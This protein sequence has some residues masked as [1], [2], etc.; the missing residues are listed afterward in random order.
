[1][2]IQKSFELTENEHN[3]VEHVLSDDF[4]WYFQPTITNR[5]MF[6]G[7][8]LMKRHPELKPLPGII[9]C[10][11][12]PIVETLFKRFC[13]ENNIKVNHVLRASINTTVYDPAEVSDIH[14]DHDFPHYNFLLYL[15]EFDNGCTIIYDKD[16]N[17]IKKIVPKKYD[18]VV[19][20]GER[21]ANQHC[22]VGQRRVVLVITFN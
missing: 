15:N 4:P 1:M 6:F 5:F 7:Y 20:D 2:F 11:C 19:F 3:F 12:Y 21:H 16:D 9:N 22:A 18:A 8:V 13:E 10:N 14:I 17:V